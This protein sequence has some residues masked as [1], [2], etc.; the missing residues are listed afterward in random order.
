MK[1]QKQKYHRVHFDGLAQMRME[2]I[3][4]VIRQYRY[5]TMLSREDFAKEYGI[6]RS[7][8]ERIET[9]KNVNILS[10]FRICD[11]FM[12]S[13]EELFQGCD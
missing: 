11:I 13:P 7:L 10:L 8:V 2:A 4:G 1:Q 12:I 9:G 5:D 6:S 3:G